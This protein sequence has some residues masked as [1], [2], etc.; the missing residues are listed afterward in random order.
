MKILLFGKGGQVGWEIQRTFGLTLP[1]WQVG[2]N[3]ML[4]EIL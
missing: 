3:R 1:H 2:V 4:A